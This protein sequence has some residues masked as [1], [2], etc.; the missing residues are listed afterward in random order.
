LKQPG[1][2]HHFFKLVTF[3]LP[4]F[5]GVTLACS[6]TGRRLKPGIANFT[7]SLGS[8]GFMGRHRE[9]LA[10]IRLGV[11]WGEVA[12]TLKVSKHFSVELDLSVVYYLSKFLT[13]RFI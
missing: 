3:A 2:I 4:S 13:I 12:V 8:L 9:D 1:G 10:L 7:S 5:F 11:S 6:S